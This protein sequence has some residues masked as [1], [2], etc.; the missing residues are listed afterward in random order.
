MH[1]GDPLLFA[2]THASE[3]IIVFDATRA[4]VFQSEG[5]ARFLDRH[6]LPD[7]ITLLVRRVLAAIASRTVAQTF[8]GR[9]CLHR[10]IGGRRWIFRVVFREGDQ[11][12]VGVFFTDESL[13]GRF[14]LNELRQRHRLTR[15]ETDV[16]RRLLDGLKNQ[17]IATELAIAEQTVKDYLSSIYEKIGVPDRF[18]L[19]RLF[20]CLSEH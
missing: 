6:A 19:L 14:D 3:R 4:I 13:S 1:G 12:L 16:L 2:I 9:I 5:A 20:V 10:V 15:R 7:E 17:E 8:P 18:S 11:P